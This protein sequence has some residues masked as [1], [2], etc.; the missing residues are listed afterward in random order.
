MIKKDKR[1]KKKKIKRK[2][3][4]NK[5][6]KIGIDIDNV[7]SDTYTALIGQFNEVFQT[8]IQM[9]EVVTYSYLEE[10]PGIEKERVQEFILDF[11]Q[12]ESFS[13][14]IR[15]Y[16]D[17]PAIVKKWASCG[18]SIH[19]IT[20]RPSSLGKI[21]KKWLEKHGF[22]VK[23]ATLDLY[24]ESLGYSSDREY[25][26]KIIQKIGIDVLIEDSKGNAEVVDI[27]VFLLDKPW[28]KGELSENV[29]RVSNWK[30]IERH[31]NNKQFN[32]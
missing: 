25:K 24:D 9:E 11:L 8:S 7:I 22:W 16:E 4:S 29:K 19:Y 18:Y 13:L 28:N 5:K 21:T 12:R 3:Q 2:K 10:Y 6:L 15:P 20:A 1:N 27:P 17:A 14:G 31:V 26:R 30:E 32:L 23:N